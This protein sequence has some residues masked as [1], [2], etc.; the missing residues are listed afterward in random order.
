MGW[1]LGE[2]LT[3]IWEVWR[4]AYRQDPEGRVLR[5]RLR[6]SRRAKRRGR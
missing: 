6:E 4:S 1:L 3:R 2:V 5:R